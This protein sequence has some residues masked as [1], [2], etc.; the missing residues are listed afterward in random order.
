MTPRE[1]MKP[2]ESKQREYGVARCN[3]GAAFILTTKRVSADTLTIFLVENMRDQAIYLNGVFESVLDEIVTAQDA[4]PHQV[5]F[6]QPYSASPI[7]YLRDNLPTVGDPVRLYISISSDLQQVRY[8]ANIV[9]WRDKSTIL[10]DSDLRR[11]ILQTLA[12]HQPGEGG[13]YNVPEDGFSC[14]LI[15]VTRMRKLSQPFAVDNLI[16]VSDD[17]PVSLNKTMPGGWMYVRPDPV[18]GVLID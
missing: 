4:N 5:L 7:V 18:G 14:N 12:T 10:H 15:Y 3:H 9:G 11:S 6:L 13:L 8:T 2:R 17:R 1:T 16:L